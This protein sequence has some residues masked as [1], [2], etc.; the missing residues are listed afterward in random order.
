MTRRIDLICTDIDGTLLDSG[1]PDFVSLREFKRELDLRKQQWGT[2][3]AIVTGRHRRG[4]LPALDSFLAF[5]LI[6][7]FI[8]LEDAYIYRFLRGTGMRGFWRW[9]FRIRWKRS[10]LW[11]RSRRFIQKLQ[12][13]MENEFPD[14]RVLSHE[15]I[16]M[17]LEFPDQPSA[18][19]GEKAL[20][21]KIAEC[22]EFEVFR[23]GCE[24]F[25]APAIG[26]KGEA[27]TRISDHLGISAEHV[28]VIGDGA[29]DVN[30]LEG[31][32]AGMVACVAN[33]PR[34]I[35]SIVRRNSGYVAKNRATA[36]VVEALR[37]MDQNE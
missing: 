1:N 22:L 2:K 27:V 29:N 30:M 9:N 5:H 4:F 26:K 19:Q 11:R 15:T 24:V 34:E 20:K 23:W 17:W 7:D 6:P 18:E 12:N 35:K 13:E 36:G 37:S 32:A 33:T 10:W 25:L 16:D 14:M 31:W 28:F 8:V 3:W 21:I